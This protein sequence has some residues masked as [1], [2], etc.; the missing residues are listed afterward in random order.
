[1]KREEILHTQSCHGGTTDRHPD[2]DPSVSFLRDSADQRLH[3]TDGLIETNEYGSRDDAVTDVV[4]YDFRN[5][6]ES[7]YIAVIQPMSCVHSDPQF[8]GQLR[9]LAN[10]L[11]LGISFFRPFCIGISTRVQLDEIGRDLMSYL[12]LREIW[13]DEKTNRDAAAVKHGNDLVDAIFVTG[14]IQSPLGGEF[15][16]VFGDK[17]DHVWFD[18][19]RDF[20]HR[21]VGGHLQVELRPNQLSKEMEIPVLDV[22]T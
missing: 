6:R 3:F 9:G 10:G 4:L 14:H 20:R 19:E 17:C 13:F 2:K 1:M 18:H 21:L 22:T 5:G 8:V 15:L 12:D 16:A 11:E 7:F